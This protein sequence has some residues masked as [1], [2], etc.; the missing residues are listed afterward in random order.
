VLLK[1]LTQA[2]IERGHFAHVAA[3]DLGQS[4]RMISSFCGLISVNYGDRLDE[5]GCQYVSLMAEAANTMRA[6]L[7]DLVEHGS[8]DFASEDTIWFDASKS[9][10]GVLSILREPIERSGA[11]VTSD[12]LPRVCGTPVRFGRILQNLIGNAIKYVA[13]GVTPRVHVSVKTDAHEWVFGVSDNGIGIDPQY[14][15]RIFEP[16]KRLHTASKYSG[17][18]MGLAICKKIVAGFGGRLWIEPSPDGGSA[19]FFSL[20]R[21]QEDAQHD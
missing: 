3:H 7:D 10:E 8:L 21:I 5:R 4:V 6:L 19:F 16:F 18:G 1:K 17:T 13:P 11:V 14:Y 12:R 9:L 2:D 15:S 20:R